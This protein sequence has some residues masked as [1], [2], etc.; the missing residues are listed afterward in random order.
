MHV[1]R[2]RSLIKTPLR[3][4]NVVR[5]G[6]AGDATA[7]GCGANG[8]GDAAARRIRFPQALLML[9]HAGY[10]RGVW[11]RYPRGRRL[12]TK[13]HVGFFLDDGCR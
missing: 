2:V 13:L 10:K 4:T 5:N 1:S 7:D 8:G 3:L 12:H 6:H 11:E 9:L